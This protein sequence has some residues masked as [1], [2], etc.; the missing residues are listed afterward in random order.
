MVWAF[1]Y[2]YLLDKRV[3]SLIVLGAIVG[4][5]LQAAM[6]APLASFVPEM[7][8]TRVRCTGSSLAF[9]L[10]GLFGG[11]LAPVIST[12]LIAGSGEGMSV[13]LYM[14]A[15]LVLVI[16]ATLLAKETSGIDLR[17]VGHDTATSAVAPK[18]PPTYG[19]S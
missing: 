9:Q 5:L 12:S 7:F 4:S 6:W 19:P 14:M 15:G 16:V 3:P 8:E 11:A 13:A 1:V 2:F 18:L 17:G 10:A